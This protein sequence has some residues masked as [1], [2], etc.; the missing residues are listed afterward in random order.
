MD[1]QVLAVGNDLDGNIQISKYDI[2][3]DENTFATPSDTKL[4][5]VDSTGDFVMKE[6]SVIDSSDDEHG[7]WR[8]RLTA[9][10][11]G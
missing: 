10:A 8:P 3:D 11:Q 6:E 7:T 2:E 5:I 9:S 1:Q 4:A